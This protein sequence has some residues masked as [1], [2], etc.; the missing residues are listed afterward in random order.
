MWTCAANV[1]LRTPN[2]GT[3]AFTPP[4]MP[5][6]KFR[7]CVR[8]RS[9]RNRNRSIGMLFG[10]NPKRSGSVA[11]SRLAFCWQISCSGSRHRGPFTSM[12]SRMPRLRIL[13]NEF[14]GGSRFPRVLE[15]GP[16][17]A[18]RLPERLF[19]PYHAVRLVR[20]ARRWLS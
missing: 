7:G 18:V 12:R 9:C 8:S 17:S 15:S 3:V 19:P 5:G 4:N 13:L 1:V 14:F 6:R 2:S 11:S 10:A 16:W 20:L